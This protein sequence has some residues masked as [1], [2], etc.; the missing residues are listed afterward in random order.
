MLFN[1]HYS[2]E[3]PST[4]TFFLFVITLHIKSILS[5]IIVYK[6]QNTAANKAQYMEEKLLP[7]FV[8]EL[9]NMAHTFSFH[10]SFPTYISGKTSVR[11]T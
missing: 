11:V 10:T 5:K 7:C 6:S 8:I 1:H 3:E 4:S 9:I 2:L